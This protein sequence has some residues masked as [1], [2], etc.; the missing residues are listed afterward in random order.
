VVSVA[1]LSTYPLNFT[2]FKSKFAWTSLPPHIG[3]LYHT[4]DIFTTHWK[5][6]PH[7]GHLYHTF[8]LIR[9]ILLHTRQIYYT[10]TLIHTSLLLKPTQ[11]H[12]NPHFTTHLHHFT[13]H[14]ANLL[15]VYANSHQFTTQTHS[16]P[17]KPHF[18]T[19]LHHFTTHK[20]NLLH[21]YANSP[22]LC[23]KLVKCVVKFNFTTPQVELLHY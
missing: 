15:H 23:G 20:A 5:I 7:I 17:L 1:W 4:L 11:I 6:L 16:N 2:F 3:H 9:T 10:F 21:V 22:N 8:D 12:S 19:H 13:T 14:K 18:T